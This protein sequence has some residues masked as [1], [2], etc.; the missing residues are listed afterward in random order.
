[1]KSRRGVIRSA[2][3]PWNGFYG[4]VVGRMRTPIGSGYQVA[5]GNGIECF[6]LPEEWE[7]C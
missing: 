4:A 7:E 3:H 1:M 6:V 5:L 2:K